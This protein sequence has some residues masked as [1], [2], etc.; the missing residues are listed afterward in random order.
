A[1][2]G[3]TG[4]QPASNP[5]G[6]L[7][8]FALGML[9]IVLM[10]T[11]T[12]RKQ[13]K[14]REQML[15]GLKRNDKVLTTAGIVGTVV[16]LYDNEFVLRVDEASNTRIRFARSAVQQILRDGKEGGRP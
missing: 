12:G 3:A 1:G 4:G 7:W 6:M 13:K 16:D 10:S 14:Q 15:T 11:M 5:M 2:S 9:V 8:I